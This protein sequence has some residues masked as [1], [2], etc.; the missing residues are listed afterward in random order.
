MGFCKAHELSF[1]KKK[2][3]KEQ[4]LINLIH[5]QDEFEGYRPRPKEKF[6]H[7]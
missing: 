1:E 7:Q 3:Q 2:T 4:A 5:V 6:W